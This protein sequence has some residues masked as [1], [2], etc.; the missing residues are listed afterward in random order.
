MVMEWTYW[1]ETLEF[2]YASKE[3]IEE[4]LSEL[5]DGG[6]E[7]VTSWTVRLPGDQNMEN[8]EWIV[9]ILFKKPK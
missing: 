2:P 4:D 5:G 8:G 9:R 7:A 3:K 6:W 1:V